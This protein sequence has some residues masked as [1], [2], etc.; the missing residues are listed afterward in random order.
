MPVFK[1][2][3]DGLTINDLNDVYDFMV[4]SY[5]AIYGDDI[6]LDGD[7]PDGQVVA[8][9]SKLNADAQ[10][11]LLQ[12]YNSFDPDNA[13]GVQLNKIIKLSALTR[14]P[15]TKS[16]VTIDLTA[17][18]TVSL[19]SN[20]TVVDELGQSWV[21]Q[22]AQSILVGTTAVD[23]SAQEWGSVAANPNTITAQGTI[24]TQITAVDNPL[25]A[26][27]GI[28]EETDEQLRIRRNKSL[29]QPA[30]STTGSLLAKL[31][32][33][34][35]VIDAIVY[36]NKTKIDNPT[37]PL[38]AN[39]LWCIV[40][41]G[42]GTDIIETIAKEKTAGA[43]LKGSITGDYLESFLRA[44]GSTRIHTH[45]VNYDVPT[46]TDIYVKV[47]V[48]PKNI[49]DV[50]DTELIKDKIAEKLLNIAEFLTITE[51][52]SYIYQAGTTF[53]ATNLTA[54]L[55]DITYVADELEATAAEKL[56]ITVAN[57]TVT[58]I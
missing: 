22:L 6:V 21:I 45:E 46:E 37:L 5:K 51:L 13:I 48:T 30:Y 35:N 3:K 40:D 28:D 24:L 20:Y 55:D 18:T 4:T 23:F 53:I 58:E 39:T 7:T 57:I 32:E 29:E 43:G 8:I 36:E 47:D 12:L 54:S 44:D 11:S 14:K 9:Y 33:T 1:L 27:I 2:D 56:V 25:A 38:V 15:A 19:E 42:L 17:S 31:L 16:T 50:I 41:G 26:A 10:A 52:Y 34:E 49:G